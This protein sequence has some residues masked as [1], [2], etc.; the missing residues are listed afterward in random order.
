MSR[1]LY[2]SCTLAGVILLACTIISGFGEQDA[3]NVRPNH[4]QKQKITIDPDEITS[5]TDTTYHKI[6]AKVQL[7]TFK[8]PHTSE[9]L[10]AA[11]FLKPSQRDKTD[12]A[13]EANKMGLF[14]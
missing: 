8:E 6:P 12:V 10:R 11:L 1:N 7:L 5:D 9:K 2:K 14:H 4:F 13:H 3:P